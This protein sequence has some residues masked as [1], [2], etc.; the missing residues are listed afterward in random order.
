MNESCEYHL[1]AAHWVLPYMKNIIEGGL[2]FTQNKNLYMEAY[3]NA[4]YATSMVD[5]RSTSMYYTFL[6]GV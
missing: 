4:N 5:I 2:L 6:V 1:Q 3:S